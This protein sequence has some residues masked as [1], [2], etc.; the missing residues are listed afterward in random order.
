MKKLL[1][2]MIVCSATLNIQ[3]QDSYADTPVTDTEQKQL[4]WCF[5][6]SNLFGY[7]I[8]Y[9]TYPQL[10]ESIRE[11]IGTPYRYSGNDK[12]GVDCSGFVAEMVDYCFKI[13]L[14]GSAN[15]F[16]K[17]VEPVKKKQLREGDLVFFKIHQKRISHVGIYLGQNKFAHSSTQR[18]VIISDLTDP[19][20][21]KYF[22]RGGR[23]EL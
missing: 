1:L 20:Y 5:E 6:Y 12:K 15:D 8:N 14:D 13:K 4:E 18:G 3:A 7:D 22:Y 23:L 9:I 11:W 19:Y 17:K 10:F 16:Y 2:A 21:E